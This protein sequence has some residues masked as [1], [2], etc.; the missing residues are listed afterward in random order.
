MLWAMIVSI[1]EF[2]WNG[3]LLCLNN[4]W[5]RTH[6]YNLHAKNKTANKHTGENGQAKENSSE[7]GHV[8]VQLSCWNDSTSCMVIYLCTG[9]IDRSSLNWLN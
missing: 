1:C 5:Q 3:I 2:Q 6:V 7:R 8:V 9:I 4:Y